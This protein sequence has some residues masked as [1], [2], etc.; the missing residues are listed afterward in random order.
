MVSTG[1]VPVVSA[2][3]NEM[4]VVVERWKTDLEILKKWIVEA[5]HALKS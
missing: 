2:R 5:E 1:A 4:T 3:F